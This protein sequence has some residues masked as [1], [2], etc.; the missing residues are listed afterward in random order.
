M[1][2]LIY[3]VLFF[4]H[5]KDNVPKYVV[6]VLSRNSENQCNSNKEWYLLLKILY[7]K[8]DEYD[9]I[10]SKNRFLEKMQKN[11]FS[12][13]INFACIQISMNEK[14]QRRNVR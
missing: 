14:I 8:N 13:R 6:L 1:I 7:S 9:V 3:C 11:A 10:V 5:R 4:M 2:F 12:I